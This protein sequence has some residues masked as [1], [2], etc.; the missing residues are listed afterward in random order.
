[1]F[2]KGKERTLFILVKHLQV[3][4]ICTT[5]LNED[6]L[7]SALLIKEEATVKAMVQNR[8]LLQ[9]VI[10]DLANLDW[11]LCRGIQIPRLHPTDHGPS[12]FTLV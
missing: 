11:N 6:I 4:G 2:Y 12:L 9:A 1:M 5:N 10:R 3:C 8:D 7:N